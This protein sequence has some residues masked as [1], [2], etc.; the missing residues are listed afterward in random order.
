MTN[1]PD[2]TI[3]EAASQIRAG[4][5]TSSA[6]TEACLKRI[7]AHDGQVNSFITLT[8]DQALAQAQQADQEIRAGSYRGPLHGIPIA[9]KDLYE[10]AGLRTTAGST[11]FDEPLPAQDACVVQKL[12][13]AGMVLLGKLNM[14][15]VALGITNENP[16]FGACRNPWD[17]RCITGGSSG[18]SAAALAARFCLGSLGSDT[19]GSIRI[20]AALCG[21]VGLKPTYGRSSLRGVVPLSWNLDHA[22]PMARCVED[23]ALLL[24]LI[25][26]YDP[27]DAYSLD[28][29]VD[30]YLAELKQGVQGWKLALLDDEYF[31]AVDPAVWEAM[32]QAV[33][34]FQR[35]GASVERLSIPEFKTYA[36]ANSL[37]V[38]SD[39]AAFHHQ[40]LQDR[41]QGFGADVL[42]RL[43]NGAAFTST[44]YSLARRTQT[45]ARRH[46]A[47]YFERYN[48]LLLPTTP[49][50]A[51]EI[52]GEDADNR[53]P[54]LTRFT[55]PFNLT[56]LPAISMP[57]GR[58]E[59]LPIGLQI[60]A[61]HWQEAA[62]LRAAY[63]FE[64][65]AP[66][67]KAAPPLA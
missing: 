25:A 21:I 49:T 50:A 54:Q 64:Q 16:H 52:G 34:V 45:L 9:L 37:L 47:S 61:N 56:G 8:A 26:G 62:L 58:V 20:P 29:P 67:A 5:L 31:R 53:A 28:A 36:Q 43:H 13:Q 55:A 51:H 19:G 2:L 33:Q 30:D 18:G 4:R 1:L 35:L 66:W 15:E 22:G 39:G 11:F 23:A 32:E 60:V 59:G 42:R 12:R 27:Q 57:A 10:T 17:T 63:A 6:L 46:M 38:T 65:A 44:E 41:P 14:H 7:A 40:R 3:H 24:G 48:L